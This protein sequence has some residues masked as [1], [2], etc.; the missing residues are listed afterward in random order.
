MKKSLIL[1]GL[2]IGT[3]LMTGYAQASQPDSVVIKV[4]E[5]SKVIFA[6]DKKDIPTLK[7]Y[8]FQA[9]MD[10]M[11]RKLEDHDTTMINNP[12]SDYLKEDKVGSETE[13][14]QSETTYDWPEDTDE[15]D[16]D[17]DSEWVTYKSNDREYRD[18]E[19]MQRH[20]R[21]R[22]TYHS[23]SLDLGTNNW[24]SN[25]KFPDSNNDLYTI[26]PIGSW[27][28]GINSIQRTALGGK[29]FLEWGGGI[30]WYNFKFENDKTLITKDDTG[31]NFS[32]DPR[33]FEFEK[34]KLTATFINASIIPVVDFGGNRRKP[35]LFDSYH[36]NSFRLGVGPY[37]G[38]RIDSYT[39][40]VYDENN[41]KKKDKDHDSFYIN[42]IRYGMRLQLGFQDVDVFFS[43][44][45][46]E[47][48]TEGK[49]PPLNAFSFGITL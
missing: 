47:F 27:F 15:D 31:V 28:V 16:R 8:D 17:D 48:F 12:S 6:I 30:S 45:M 2:I 21:G 4:G 40:L 29:F 34:S 23:I 11:I 44:D 39:K 24:L 37:V 33:D 10:D 49:G 13:V 20:R 5:S 14:T 18:S 1:T 35:M 26:R 46:N 9:L 36:S 22:R 25:G 38:Y 32:I 19:R 42:N 43:Y 7:Y 41:D 3:Y